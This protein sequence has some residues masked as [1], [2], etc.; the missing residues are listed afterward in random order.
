MLFRS[1]LLLDVTH[2]SLGIETLGGV[3]T[4]LIDKHTTVPTK[5]SQVFSTA[6]DNQP[7]VSIHVLQGEREMAAD[8]KTIGRFELTDLPPA[9]RGVPQIEVSFDLDANGILNVSAKD[10]GTNKEQSIRITA[11]SGLSEDEIEKMKQD[12]EEHAEEDK[13]RKELVDARNNADGLVHA[14]GKSLKDLGDKVDEE[15]QASV[16]KEIENVKKTIE[17]DDTAAINAAI[18]E[19]TKVSHKL[20]EMMY[21]NA[22][23]EGAPGAGAGAAGAADTEQQDDRSEERRV[24]KDG[25]L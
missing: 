5:K 20:A 25:R 18:E 15:T 21:A 4:K 3:T 17:G 23:Q 22:S 24:G 12:A 19:L 16:E 13:K 10:M 2:L 8:N 11:S 7:A 6:A 14:S 1:V 9:S